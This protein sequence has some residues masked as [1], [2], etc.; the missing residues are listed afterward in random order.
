MT[1]MSGVVGYD[2]W[3]SCRFPECAVVQYYGETV[4]FTELILL[5]PERLILP[6][7]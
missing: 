3:A 2:S 5:F 4:T 6:S 7:H 1:R